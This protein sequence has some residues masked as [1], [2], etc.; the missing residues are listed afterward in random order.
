[1][2][3]L[4]ADRSL[5][6]ASLSGADEHEMTVLAAVQDDCNTLNTKLTAFESAWHVV[7]LACSQLLADVA[8]ARSYISV[9]I[10]GLHVDWDSEADI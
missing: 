1:M 9:I 7:R 6:P 4:R 3:T 10:V 5:G 2:L 8:L